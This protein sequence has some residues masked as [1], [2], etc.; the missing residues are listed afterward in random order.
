MR[1][2]KGLLQQMGRDF[3]SSMLRMPARAGPGM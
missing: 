2:A 1:Y 3:A